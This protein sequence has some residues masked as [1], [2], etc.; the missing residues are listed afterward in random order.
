MTHFTLSLIR[1]LQERFEKQLTSLSRTSIRLMGPCL[2]PIAVLLIS[3]CVYIFYVMLLPSIQ[4]TS[5]VYQIVWGAFAFLFTLCTINVYFNY[6][7]A[8][9]TKS[10][11]SVVLQRAYTQVSTVRLYNSHFLG[12]C[13]SWW[14]SELPCI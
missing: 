10:Y 2:I 9:R 1:S 11:V 13:S 12:V 3:L 5:V 8:I 14:D 4:P 6:L 7:M